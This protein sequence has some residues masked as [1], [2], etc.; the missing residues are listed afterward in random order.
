MKKLNSATFIC[1]KCKKNMVKT[2]IVETKIIK[3]FDE[4]EKTRSGKFEILGCDQI[5]YDIVDVV[6]MKCGQSLNREQ[7]HYFYTQKEDYN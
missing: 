4:Y 3:L 5:V 7:E 1:T 2:G 6:C